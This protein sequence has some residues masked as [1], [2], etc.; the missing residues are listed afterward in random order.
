MAL[1][2]EIRPLAAVS[3]HP[4]GLLEGPRF[5]SEGQ[6]VFS[7]VIGGGLWECSVLG[8]LKEIIPRRRGI[9]GVV[10]HAEGGWV[11]SGRTILHITPDGEQREILAEAGSCGYNDLGTTAEG[12]L[13]VGALRY[14]PL[15]GE[16][17]VAGQILSIGADG[18][19][20]VLNE[21]IIWPNGIGVSP[22]G[23]TIYVSDYARQAVFAMRPDGSKCREFAG[24]PRGSADG[25]AV[26]RGGRRVDRPR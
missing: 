2:S 15:A 3:E 4:F 6:A 22:G 24:S 10:A 18:Q 19:V 13:L 26:D 25:L 16:S 1:L 23:E 12:E 7:D 17:E 20:R 9:G 8:E 21:Q 5:G 11:I 14:R